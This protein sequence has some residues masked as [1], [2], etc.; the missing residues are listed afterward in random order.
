MKRN[1]MILAMV[2]SLT[3]ILAA[4]GVR[5]EVEPSGGATTSTETEDTMD[6]SKD[7][8]KEEVNDTETEDAQADTEEPEPEPEEEPEET[9]DK[10]EPSDGPLLPVG[11][12]DGRGNELDFSDYEGKLLLVNFFGTWCHFCMEEMP[13]FQKF[14]EEYGDQATIVLVNAL[15]TESTDMAGVHEWYDSSG[16]TMPMIIDEDRSKTLDFYSAIQGY[17]TT[18]VYDENHNFLGY[19]GGKM[20]YAMLEQIVADY[21]PQQ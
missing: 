16:Y 18:F 5:E 4:C 19:V 13:D 10:S 3:M 17:P 9:S 12:S 14:T 21:G 11:M 20:E 1:L 15:E 8:P 7:E 6:E 2:L